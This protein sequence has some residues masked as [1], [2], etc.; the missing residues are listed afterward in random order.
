[1]TTEMSSKFLLMISFMFI[2]AKLFKINW[3]IWENYTKVSRSF[4]SLFFTSDSRSRALYFR[5]R[6]ILLEWNTSSRNGFFSPVKKLFSKQAH[7]LTFDLG[8]VCTLI[9]K[10]GEKRKR[11]SKKPCFNSAIFCM[12]EHFAYDE[13]NYFSEVAFV[14]QTFFLLK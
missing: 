6:I 14:P 9:V 3:G 13:K 12:N 7:F 10:K 2:T 8:E 4:E 11:E 5:I 1:M